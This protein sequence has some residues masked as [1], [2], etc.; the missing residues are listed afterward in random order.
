MELEL[1]LQE[2]DRVAFSVKAVEVTFANIYKV[3]EWCGGEIE[4]QTTRL[5]GTDTELP[6]IRIKGSQGDNQGRDFIATLGCYVVELKGNYRVY[7][8]TQFFKAFEKKEKPTLLEE[9]AMLDLKETDN[10]ATTET[11]LAADALHS[12]DFPEG[13]VFEHDDIAS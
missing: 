3:A 5:L 7:K 8:S 10:S 4:T 12:S 1:D 11:L 13:T 2:Y 9:S 6:V